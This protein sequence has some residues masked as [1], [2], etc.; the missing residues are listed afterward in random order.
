MNFTEIVS[1][2]K[3]N[4]TKLL[5]KS[6]RTWIKDL[7]D[8]SE[9]IIS[10]SPCWVLTRTKTGSLKRGSYISSSRGRQ[11]ADAQVKLHQVIENIW[12][13]DIDKPSVSK[14]SKCTLGHFLLLSK[15]VHLKK[16]FARS[17][18]RVERGF[19]GG[20]REGY[21]CSHMC[22]NNLCVNPSH[23][24]A[25]PYWVNR[26]AR[27]TCPG[28]SLCNCWRLDK[29][30]VSNKRKCKVEGPEYKAWN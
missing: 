29:R 25:D 16:R 27:K 12:P 4:Q 26:E 28:P 11:G 14:T 5:K 23:L 24:V 15:P 13:S 21:D 10:S 30:R 7:S 8:E 19:S 18:K 20:K 1:G 22:H 9:E 17:T 3:P 2:L 6:I